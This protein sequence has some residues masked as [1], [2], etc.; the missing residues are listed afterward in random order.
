VL[1]RPTVVRL[2]SET[3]ARMSRALPK[4]ADLEPFP[5]NSA[6]EVV[7]RLSGSLQ[8]EGY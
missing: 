3:R 7:E 6:G 2:V 4:V 8:E 5:L 1:A